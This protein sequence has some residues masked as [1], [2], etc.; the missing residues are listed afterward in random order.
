M[1]DVAGSVT[2]GTVLVF[3]LVLWRKASIASQDT[4]LEFDL[5]TG[6]S[7]SCR[8]EFVSRI[9]S[10]DDWN[11]I[12]VTESKFL[13]R[14]FHRERKAVA[15][16]WVRQ[17]SA[18]IRQILRE[19]TLHVRHSENLKFQTE[20]AIFLRYTQLRALCG[21][22]FVAIALAGPI[23]VRGLALRADLLFQRFAKVRD[24]LHAASETQQLRHVDSI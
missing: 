1:M 11:F 24:S 10:S 6:S 23:W 3:V 22:L 19:H 16:L 15:L 5:L 21:L 18:G 9:F 7:E 2:I 4:S 14:L 13:R 17:T 20:L 12:D 8:Q